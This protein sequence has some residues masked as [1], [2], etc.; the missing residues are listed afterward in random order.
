MDDIGFVRLARLKRTA[1]RT[2]I[3]YAR[4]QEPEAV[5]ALGKKCVKELM[6]ELRDWLLTHQGK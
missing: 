2:L 5:A 4:Q 3:S 1:Q 6:G